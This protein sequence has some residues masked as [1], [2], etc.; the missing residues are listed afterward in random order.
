MNAALIEAY[1]D[2][3][4]VPDDWKDQYMYCVPDTWEM[5]L[6][7]GNGSC[8]GQDPNWPPLAPEG[9][10]WSTSKTA[11][12]YKQM[13]DAL[14]SQDRVIL[15]SICDWGFADVF[16]WGNDT[17]ISWRASGDIQKDWGR[18][19]VNLNMNSFKMN[20]VNF[21]SHNDGDL[22]EVGNGLNPQQSRSHF[23]LWAAMKSPLIISTDVVNMSD[24]DLGWISNKYLI[25]FN[26]GDVYGEAAQPYKWGTNPNWTFDPSSPAEFWAG[27]SKNGTLVVIFNPSGNDKYQETT[28][29]EIPGLGG[30]KR[31]VINVWTGESVGCMDGYSVTVTAYDAE[32][33]LVQDACWG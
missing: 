8:F 28:F 27:P 22:L 29:S 12:R 17:A 5:S 3:C 32:V 11:Q 9:Y 19:M 15:L 1:S 20:S 16:E 24:Q 23:A 6:Q 31:N 18:I 25:E 4:N 30:W 26:Q 7:D 2:N 10:D 14:D 21:W 13:S 33:I